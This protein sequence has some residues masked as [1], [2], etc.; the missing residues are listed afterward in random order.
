MENK[1][2]YYAIIPADVRYD[3]R[4]S[5]TSK[6]IFGELTTVCNQEGYCWVDK[7]K[8]AKKFGLVVE[9]ITRRLKELEDCGYITTGENNL[10]DKLKSKELHG[11][12]YGN[13]VCEWCK[14]RTTVLHEH[15][16]PVPKSKGG[17]ATVSICPNC[18]HEFHYNDSK[19]K[20]NVPDSQLAQ[21][22]KLRGS[23]LVE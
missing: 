8:L 3:G 21:I 6:I 12:G 22:L 23:G 7:N 18:H 5:A 10:I 20:L 16:Y 11:L 17:D 4:L 19:I 2:S 15:H 1:R 14:I 13:K 9:T